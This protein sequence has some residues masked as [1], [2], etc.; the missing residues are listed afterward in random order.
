VW[1]RAFAQCLSTGLPRHLSSNAFL[2]TPRSTVLLE[3]IKV[4]RLITKISANYGT[5]T[6][7]TVFTRTRYMQLSWEMHFWTLLKFPQFSNTSENLF[8][9][10][11]P[12]DR[13]VF[14]RGTFA[15][16]ILFGLFIHICYMLKFFRIAILNLHILFVIILYHSF[17]LNVVNF[18]HFSIKLYIYSLNIRQNVW[19]IIW[20][21][22]MCVY[23]DNT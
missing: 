10:A 3:K 15:A 20:T 9:P 17:F 22:M 16:L 6:F 1:V 7:I 2:I 5:G 8:S 19:I 18:S 4:A 11:L 12:S 13:P 14:L 23:T 21:Y